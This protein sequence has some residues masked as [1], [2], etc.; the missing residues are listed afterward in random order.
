MF[1]T[2]LLILTGSA[3]TSVMLL[4]RNLIIARLITLE[5]YGIAAT[6]A[7]VMA[8]VE[9]MSTLGL[10][11]QIVQSPR[12]D[13]PH[14]Q[15]ALQGFQVL[16][17]VITGVLMFAV[18]GPLA[19]FLHVPDIAWAYQMMA[20]VPV[21]TALV[22]FDIYRLNRQMIYR[23]GILA[24]GV[25][26]LVSL[27]LVW[28]LYVMFGDWRVML[29]AILAQAAGMAAVSHIVSKTP[30]RMVL[31]R[32]IM[33]DNLRFGWPLLVNGGLLFLVFNGEKLVVGRELGMAPL[34]IFAMGI[35]LTLTPTLISAASAQRFFLP[36][37]SAAV[38]KD[39]PEGAARFIHLSMATAQVSLVIGCLLVIGVMLVGKPVVWALLGSEYAPL[40]PL[41]IWM[42]I[43]S[44]IR[45]FKTG[46]NVI[47]LARGRTTNALISN[48]FRIASIAVSWPVLNAGGTLLD[49]IIIATVGEALGFV[50]ALAQ[51]RWRLAMSLRALALPIALAAVVLALCAL[52]GLSLGVPIW[53][54]YGA[55]A[56]VFGAM[57]YTMHDLRT[58]VRARAMTS[59]DDTKA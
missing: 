25:P 18:A 7:V 38:A 4:A 42:A 27:V 5:D 24:V 45:V 1:R 33:R 12:G 51:V 56:L 6:F 23:P 49:V 46:S 10:Q 2:A 54:L 21:L 15:S 32:A 29:Y 52:S 44:G 37:L 28:P 19:A 40:L 48:L 14:Y 41:M 58:Y 31:D 9:M 36:Q 22:H 30:Y 50:A 43:L 59:F 35:T 39:T 3:A 53:L 13:D 47:A 20:A 26:A 57:F 17:G 11:Q 34:A 16:R 8:M 55:V